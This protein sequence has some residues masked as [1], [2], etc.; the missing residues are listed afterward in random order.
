MILARYV[1]WLHTGWPAG[2]VEPLPVVHADGTTAVPG[3]RIVGD[4]TGIPLLKFAVDTGA[5]AVQAIVAEPSFA[6]ANADANVNVNVSANVN[7]N[8]SANANANVNE[9]LDLVIVGAGVSGVSAALEAKRY[10]LRFRLFEAAQPFG[11][12]QSFPKQKPI[13]T[14]PTEMKPAG[15]MTVSASVKE[16]LFAE[17]ETQRTQAGIEVE[18]AEIDHLSHKG[19]LLT[20]HIAGET[21]RTVA[22]CRAIIAIGR[23][24]NYRR[25]GCPG[26]TL[27]KVLERLYDPSDYAGQE[28]LVVG[29]G[30]SAV[31]SAI[32]LGQAGARVTLSYRQ[33]KLSRPKPENLAKLET[34]A[35]SVRLRLGSR[36]TEIRPS[37]VVLEDAEGKPVTLPNEVVFPM[38]GREAPLAFFRRSGIPIRGEWRASTW[39]GFLAFVAFGFFLYNW[40]AGGALNQAF[41]RHHWF[42]YNLEPLGSSP[43]LIAL[44]RSL[45]EPGFYYSIAYTVCVVLF[46]IARI[47]R[48]RTPYVTRQTLIL[49]GFQVVPLFFVPYLLLPWAGH[50]GLFDA[51]AGKS[52][53]DALFP[54]VSYGQGREYWRAFGLVLA[55]PLFIWNFFTGK[56]MT[57]WLVIGGV[58]T[59]VLIPLLVRRWGKGAYCGFICAAARWPKP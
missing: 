58:Q 24:G 54:V 41:V 3:V 22:A 34:L 49:M 26:E 21:P 48:R 8:A 30:D 9:V 19:A 12:I 25:L 39:A 15:E 46:G 44:S 17:L 31:E 59:F 14:Y 53:A 45:S 13:F 38:I 33:A 6:N 37:E 51:G 27:D 1:R 23:S 4:L 57:W 28:V 50:A 7:A 35:G 55:W 2:T 47:R 43:F 42:P 52:V 36:V 32:A 18:R 16:A 40:K 11:T 20:V 56:P 10:G 5:R 29:G